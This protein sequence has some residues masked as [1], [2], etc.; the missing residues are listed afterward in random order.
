MELSIYSYLGCKTCLECC[1][2]WASYAS[3]HGAP[4]EGSQY[5]AA[6]VAWHGGHGGLL[7]FV[8]ERDRM[9]IEWREWPEGSPEGVQGMIG[10]LK[11][12]RK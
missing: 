6:F 2:A 7:S 8:S 11:E 10:N 9:Q 3:G 12:Y 5:L 1:P 4:L